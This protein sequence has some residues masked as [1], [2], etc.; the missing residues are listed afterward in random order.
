M[1]FS[2]IYIRLMRQLD[3]LHLF[4][5]ACFILLKL[6]SLAMTLFWVTNY[7]KYLTTYLNLDL[8][9]KVI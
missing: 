8:R 9:N 3:C 5:E 7:L 1:M 4:I 6:I 2:F